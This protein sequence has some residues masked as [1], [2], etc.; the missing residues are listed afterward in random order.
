MN[1]PEKNEQGR[2]SIIRTLDCSN[3]TSLLPRQKH[4]KTNTILRKYTNILEITLRSGVKL[5]LTII[6][7]ISVFGHIIFTTVETRLETFVFIYYIS[8][9]CNNVLS[10]LLFKM[11]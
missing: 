8:V 2:R 3:L 1:F 5:Y 9:N 11:L 10:M 6:Y 4:V 7:I